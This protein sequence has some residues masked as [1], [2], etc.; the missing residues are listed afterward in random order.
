MLVAELERGRVLP[1][2]GRRRVAI[3]A[4]S[5]QV[6]G[7]EYPI[8]R[9]AGDRVDV[10]VD[11]FA[12]G[13]AAI[14]A[15]VRWRRAGRQPWEETRMVPLG[16]DR[17]L[18]SFVVPEVG[19]YHYTVQG[20]TD[21]FR[22]WREALIKRIEGSAVG[23]SDVDEGLGLIEQA[24]SGL[25]GPEA[26]RLNRHA[27][28]IRNLVAS[29][30]ADAGRRALDPELLALMDAHAP[31]DH[32]VATHRELEVQVDPPR[33]RHSAWYELFPRSTSPTPGRHGTFR[34]VLR[35][36]PYIASMGFDVLYFPPIHPIGRS[37]RKGPNNTEGAGP[38]DPGS[39]WAIG[40]HEGGHTS[41][42][43]QLGTLEEFRE[44]VAAARSHGLEVALDL[45]FQCSPD[46]PWVREHP[47][48]FRHRPDGS[49]RTAENPPKKY[50]DIYPLDFE[51]DAWRPL[52][53]E[54][55][56]VVNYWIDQGIHLFR[57]DNPHTKPFEFWRW[58][59]GEVRRSHPDVLFLAEAFTRPKVMYELAKVGFHHSYTYFAWRNSKAELTDYFREITG[60]GI[61]EFF[62]PHLWTNTPDILT[63]GLQNGGRPAFLARL[64]LAATL[65]PNYG[66]FGPSFELGEA[67]PLAPGMEEYLNSEKYQLRHWNTHAPGSLSEMIGRV[68]RIR[69]ANPAL[70]QEGRV[71]FHGVDNDQLLVYS[72]RTEDRSNAVLVCVNLDSRNT[73]SG[74]TQLSLD[75]LGIHWDE[76]FQVHDLLVDRRYDWHGSRN[77]VELR[78]HEMPAHI[79]RVR[80][81][82]DPTDGPAPAR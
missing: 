3:E 75:E 64:V 30:P 5:P 56:R 48:W 79:F 42:H 8:K 55:A 37:H 15:V 54:L 16:N 7:G 69:R 38:E 12:D 19:T 26:S 46:H 18:G 44:L 77:Y 40:S 74:W 62:R 60:A 39:P 67:R 25:T 14:G 33:A 72:R 58:L 53:E 76:S 47:E 35:W 59:L 50:E 57:V 81:R 6:D 66:I 41:I 34:D 32:A 13:T 1:A 10:E 4:V 29:A 70:E 2:D 52:W 31:R 43:P 63:V 80:R 23:R 61:R 51:T 9:I 36:L 45:A 82:G 22:T 21:A 65:A 49:I 17:W 11:I 71:F 73:Q 68:N 27:E 28:A 24:R 78:P 20:W